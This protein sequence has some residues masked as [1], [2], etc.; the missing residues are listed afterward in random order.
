MVVTN[1]EKIRIQKETIRKGDLGPLFNPRKQ[2]EARTE[3]ANLV[4]EL[5][6]HRLLARPHL[7]VRQRLDLCVRHVPPLRHR[8]VQGWDQFRGTAPGQRRRLTRLR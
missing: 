8:A 5:E 3:I 7:A 1:T 2:D 6:R 4:D